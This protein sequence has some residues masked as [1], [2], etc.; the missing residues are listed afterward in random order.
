MTQTLLDY[1]SAERAR[2]RGTAAALANAPAD[3]EQ[4]VR[5]VVSTMTGEW[6]MEQVRE[7]VEAQGLFPNSNA[8][9]GALTGALAREGVIIWTGRF[10]NTRAKRTHC[11]PSRVWRLAC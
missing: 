3:W 6:R 7:Q 11:H 1:D 9:W 4:E 5:R 8:A 2:E 10:E